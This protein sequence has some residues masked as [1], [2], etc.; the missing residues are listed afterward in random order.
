MGAEEK[1]DAT[2]SKIEVVPVDKKNRLKVPLYIRDV[3]IHCNP[4]ALGQQ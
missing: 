1:P 4:I 3:T 2:L